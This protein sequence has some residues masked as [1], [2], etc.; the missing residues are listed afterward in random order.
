[1]GT[2]SQE[3]M[4]KDAKSENSIFA[5]VLRVVGVVCD[6][7]GLSMVFRP[8]SVIADVIP[9][10][11]TIV[12]AGTGIVS[13]LLGLAW[14]LVVIAVAWLRFRPLIAGGLIAVAV[15]LVVMS[16]MK[17]RSAKA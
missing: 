4:F 14:S 1:M 6:Y 3:A 13:F 15:A 11:G 9:I 8:L 16:Y 2:V 12:G 7:V 17:G 10:L 5:W